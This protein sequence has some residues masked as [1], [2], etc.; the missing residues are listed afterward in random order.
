MK[1]R[2]ADS[3][4][5]CNINAMIVAARISLVVL[6]AVIF[7]IPLVSLAAKDTSS[8]SIDCMPN[9]D[10][11]GCPPCSM[12]KKVKEKCEP[13]ITKWGCPCKSHVAP[14]GGKCV[15][16]NNCQGSK[17]KN[18]KGKTEGM[19]K[20]S[21]AKFDKFDDPKDGDGKGDGK[22]DEGGEKGGGGGDGKGIMEALK[23]LMEMLKGAMKGGGGGDKG[24]QPPPPGQ[25]GCTAHYQVTVPSSDRCAYYVPPT[26][27]SLLYNASGTQ[28]NITSNLLDALNGG[29][30]INLNT[31]LGEGE[32]E[33]ASVTNVSDQLNETASSLD[34]KTP[35]SEDDAESTET[36]TA[37][38]NLARQAV[39]LQSGTRGNIEIRGE[40]ATVVAQA[41]DAE[42]NTEVAGFYG[43]DTSGGLPQGI[44]A[45]LCRT[46]PWAKSIVT[47]VIP[48]SFFDSLC[49]W[50]GYQVGTP[51]PPSLP[52]VQQNAGKTTP[53]PAPKSAS[54]PTV[55]P[56]VD[57]WAVPEKVPLGARTSVF[58]NTKGVESCVITSPDGSFNENNLSGGAATVP[59][60]GPTTF[61]ISCLTSDEKPVTDYV[62]VNLAI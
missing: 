30:N 23:G 22:G 19:H 40:G 31:N 15:A 14:A 56:E 34:T 38:G 28:S 7:A 36:T 24:Q 52:V 20:E 32:D 42:A 60:S 50:R 37:L 59:L 35:G 11:K 25:E 45:K 13:D 33:G 58:W 21:D 27:S 57:I 62:T 29:A 6:L 48:P 46:R 17:F 49:T 47:Y 43:S 18:Q 3:A 8:D 51:A 1:I 5:S 9:A 26:S 39:N 2:I 55:A 44:V 4:S 54:T 16:T 61:T 12:Q 10:P 41:R 53:P